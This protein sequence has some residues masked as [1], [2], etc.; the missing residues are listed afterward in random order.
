MFTNSASKAIFSIEM[1]NCS[2]HSPTCVQIF[3][4]YYSERKIFENIL[5][6]ILHHLSQLT[7]KRHQS[8]FWRNFRTWTPNSR[9][10]ATQNRPAPIFFATQPRKYK[11]RGSNAVAQ[12]SPS[13][14]SSPFLPHSTSSVYQTHSAVLFSAERKHRFQNTV[15]PALPSDAGASTQVSERRA[16]N[17]SVY[18]D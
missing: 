16:L 14:S 7:R 9:L 1:P 10:Q 15:R 3:Q 17:P 8:V 11:P 2:S 5:A 12:R 18:F 4:E 6:P 13:V